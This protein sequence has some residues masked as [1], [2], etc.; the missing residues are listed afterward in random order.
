M[1]RTCGR[2]VCIA[3]TVAWVVTGALTRGAELPPDES[4]RAAMAASQQPALRAYLTALQAKCQR[5]RGTG[6]DARAGDLATEAATALRVAQDLA[7]DAGARVAVGARVVPY[8][9]PA[10]SNIK[11][12]LYTFPTDGALAA[13]LRVVAAQGEFE[14]ASFV[15]YPL[16]DVARATVAV[17]ELAGPVGKLPAAAVTVRVVK[18]WYQG[19]TA[20]HSY[21]ADS[22]GRELVPEL[23]LYDETLVKVDRATRDS[24]LRVDYPPPRG[25]E[26]VWISSPVS[27][28]VPFN[29]HTEPVADAKA[30]RP[31]TLTAGEFKQFWVTVAA[32]AEAVGVYTGTITV[33]LDGQTT[34]TVPF[35]VRVLPFALPDPKTYYDLSRVYYTSI[36]NTNVLA[37]YVKKNG[38]DLEKAKT[39]LFNEYVNMRDH[40][41]LYPLVRDFHLGGE[42]L[43]ETQLELYRKAGLRTDTI[44]GAVPGIPPYDWLT[45]PEVTQNPLDQQ[46]MPD[47][48]I[49]RIDVGAELVARLL[50]HTNVYCF[51][52]DEPGMRILTA[53]RKPW[54]YLHEKGLHTYSTA[55]DGH[56]AYGGYNED[57]VNYGG[58]PPKETADK[59]H[60]FGGRITSYAGPHTGPENPDFARR[61][62][63]FELYKSNCDGTNNYILNGSPWNDFVGTEYNFRS[64]NLVYPGSETPIDTLE[65]EGFREGIDDVRY[66]TL[67]QQAARQAMA[68]GRTDLVYQ[69]R[70]ALQWLALLDAK[71][72]DLNAARRE[73]IAYLLKLGAGT[74]K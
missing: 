11:R 51:G 10:I 4:W 34:A 21:F 6:A 30:L 40:N 44:F 27:I 33:T 65:W 49:R 70:M 42:K 60:A 39:R 22:T 12:S 36:Y 66:A 13:P 74:A 8:T 23:L 69:G 73:M 54:R 1:R 19:G 15:L 43:L 28:E 7:A 56:L 67:L 2:F 63:G 17:S 31:V 41:V 64:F 5:A 47:D 71:K 18:L 9:V 55:H 46:P 29:D 53:E 32:P 58:I 25:P 59:W 24:Y 37:E 61:T 45:S 35:A 14:P 38:G 16:A 62:H 50:G 20:W 48:L 52:W 68:T 57:F 72:C 26:Y 3:A